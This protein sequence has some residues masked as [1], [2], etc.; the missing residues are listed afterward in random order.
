MS[1]SLRPLTIK[2]FLLVSFVCFS[3]V[4]ITAEATTYNIDLQVDFPSGNFTGTEHVTFKNT[5]S[6]RFYE[7]FFRLYPN[8]RNFY[9]DGNLIIDTVRIDNQVVSSTL[10]S[11]DTVL[12]VPL[13]TPL[14]PGGKTVIDFSFHGRLT[15]WRRNRNKSSANDY[16]VYA[17]SSSAM[18]MAEC[19][20]ILAPYNDETGWDLD[21]VSAIGDAVTSDVADYTVTVTVDEGIDV[22]TSGEV[23]K[24]ESA[25]GKRRYW[26]SGEGIRDFMIVVVKGYEE[27]ES[28]QNGVL[29]RVSFL[30]IYRQAAD[31]ALDLGRKALSLYEKLFGRYFS[32]EVDIVEVPLNR[33]AGVEYPGLILVGG[34][35]CENPYDQFFTI[36]VAHEM[37]HQWWYAAV[38]SNVTEEPWLDEALATY[39]SVV[40]IEREWGER[41]ARSLLSS[42]EESYY[43]AKSAYPQ[44]SVGSSVY[45]FPDSS[46]YSAFVYD[47]G[48]EFLNDVRQRI[49]D[50]A[51]FSALSGYYHDLSGAIAHRTDL[52]EHFEHTCNCGIGDL[53]AR[54]FTADSR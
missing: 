12:L 17:A 38:G 21:R 20:P 49:G 3:L 50:D 39:S 44:L 10:F 41:S 26:F 4:V 34:S 33:A 22:V 5:S 45:L 18:T 24:E 1:Q 51:F 19:Y 40:F 8:A 7:L 30:P 46:V 9:G 42:W 15:D 16:G 6:S 25:G 37:A 28:K 11:N 14:P 48:A 31:K 36:I 32:R 27:R 53:V 29:I 54:Y 2:A 35:Y 47:G 13:P 23:V 52:I 43:R